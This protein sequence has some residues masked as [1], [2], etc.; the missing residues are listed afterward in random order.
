[1]LLAWQ[2]QGITY[3]VT[4]LLDRVPIRVRAASRRNSR[5]AGLVAARP[6]PG[7]H[8]CEIRFV[9]SARAGHGDDYY[10]RVTGRQKT[11]SSVQYDDGGAQPVSVRTVIRVGGIAAVGAAPITYSI[12]RN[13]NEA[14][15][16]TLGVTPELLGATEP[17]LLSKAILLALIFGGFVGSVIASAAAGWQGGSVTLEHLQLHH[18]ALFARIAAKQGASRSYPERVRDGAARAL[19]KAIAIS[20]IAIG[21][22]VMG[23]ATTYDFTNSAIL[24]GA[25]LFFIAGFT[26]LRR[27]NRVQPLP[28]PPFMVRLRRTSGLKS[29]LALVALAVAG[30]ALFS[31]TLILDSSARGNG[32][33]LLLGDPPRR[34]F[35]TSMLIAGQ[36][37]AAQ[38]VPLTDA[39]PLRLCGGAAWTLLLGNDDRTLVL[40]RYPESLNYPLQEPS[41]DVYVAYAPR[42]L[43]TLKTPAGG[44]SVC[45]PL[46]AEGGG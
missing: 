23:L 5:S 46:G 20:V 39:D 8:R 37:V 6:F 44:P 3:R 45:S 2:S 21:I 15:A 14:Y 27:L 29:L 28:K 24:L 11:K 13:A 17:I 12:T 10:R 38:V 32:R 22:V 30:W 40:I 19:L 18:S 34:N 7:F 35:V 36:P 42:D 4:S 16:N 33:A 43:Y 9:S 26:M 31:G 41:S 25:F 1:M